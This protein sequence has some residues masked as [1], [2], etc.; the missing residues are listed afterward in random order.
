MPAITHLPEG[1]RSS[2]SMARV[3]EGQASMP[4]SSSVTRLPEG[5]ADHSSSFR[6]WPWLENQTP[7]TTCAMC[8][9]VSALCLLCW[10]CERCCLHRSAYNR[11]QRID[12]R[13]AY[14]NAP[15][16]TNQG[17]FLPASDLPDRAMAVGTYLLWESGVP[18]QEGRLSGRARRRYDA[19]VGAHLLRR[20]HGDVSSEDEET[21]SSERTTASDREE[22]QE[23]WPPV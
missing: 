10:S 2:S 6:F 15:A 8:G 22:E 9:N 3:P 14:V 7:Q 17:V 1:A 5:Q 16:Q 4:G 12:V 21:P 19:M 20:Q 23:D 13:R 11:A 18:T